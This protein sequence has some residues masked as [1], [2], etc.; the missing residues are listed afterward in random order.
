ME[1][2]FGRMLEVPC[3]NYNPASKLL[4]ELG[5]DPSLVDEMLPAT[6]YHELSS[7]EQRDR[8]TTTLRYLIE[9]FDLRPL[10]VLLAAR[11]YSLS[12]SIM[13]V[14]A[15][16]APSLMEAFTR[17]ARYE[18]IW[19]R[20]VSTGVSPRSRRGHI[21]IEIECSGD[22]EDV[23]V[24][25]LLEGVIASKLTYA[26]VLSPNPVR[27][28]RVYFAHPAPLNRE[29]FT[30]FFE[31]PIEYEAETN[32]IEFDADVLA[33]PTRL[34]D[35][36]I[37]EIAVGYLESLE[38]LVSDHLRS[39]SVRTR[40]AIKNT[41][42]ERMPTCGQ[43]ARRLGMSERTLRRRL[44]DSGTS[45]DRI[46]DAVRRDRA[47]ELLAL[48]DLPLTEVA[49]ALGFASSSAFSRAFRR[50]FGLRPSKYRT[51]RAPT[52]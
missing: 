28:R 51:L 40:V 17:V 11:P 36:V 22:P 32:S 16:S 45:F 9:A 19:E 23:G 31:A 21:R 48:T 29:L 14:A 38:R 46:G 47:S 10:P 8:V 27:P 25:V 3:R 35:P 49:F 13:K 33:M 30:E 6:T 12:N 2:T 5:H 4:K 7:D 42:H 20:C 24:Q 44:R 52:R 18:P 43:I 50:W 15:L 26:R 37:S 1:T 39:S 34:P 41:L